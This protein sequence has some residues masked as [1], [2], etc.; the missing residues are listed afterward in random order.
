[1]KAKYIS[2]IIGVII[3]GISCTKPLSE[4]EKLFI[5][6]AKELDKLIITLKKLYSNKSREFK[7]EQIGKSI[8]YR[9]IIMK[10]EVGEKYRE[11]IKKKWMKINNNLQEIIQQDYSGKWKDDAMFCLAFGYMTVANFENTDTYDENA[12]RT[13]RKF[14]NDYP[15]WQI[16]KLT[17][18][19]LKRSYFNNLKEWKKTS[20]EMGFSSNI[21]DEEE[22]KALFQSAIGMQMMKIKEYKKAI[23]EYNEVIR[24]YPT[25]IFAGQAKMQIEVCKELMEKEGER[26]IETRPRKQN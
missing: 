13:M 24:E 9:M 6:T 8:R 10:K 11:E 17:K 20:I 4:E 21:S 22:T 3:I 15:K 16:E 2:V 26:K 5:T 23:K 12:I 7:E 18:K 1:M 25:S 19:I 14:I